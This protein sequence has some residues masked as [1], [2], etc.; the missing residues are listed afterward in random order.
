MSDDVLKTIAAL[1]AA[2]RGEFIQSRSETARLIGGVREDLA[3]LGAANDRTPKAGENTRDEVRE[4]ANSLAV[5]ERIL[6]KHGL[7]LDALEK[8]VPK[9]SG[10]LIGE[11]HRAFVRAVV[12]LAR[13]HGFHRLSL[14]FGVSFADEI[15]ARW[16]EGGKIS[17]S[18][19]AG[20]NNVIVLTGAAGRGQGV[21]HVV[22]VRATCHEAACRDGPRGRTGQKAET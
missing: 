12:V 18:T 22:H 17:L 3:V 5:I 21:G 1:G 11:Q 14:R 2:L 10:V 8:R 16:E 4:V 13:E 15:G 19:E 7:R 20:S 9:G 6:L